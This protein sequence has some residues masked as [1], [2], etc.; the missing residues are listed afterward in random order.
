MCSSAEANVRSYDLTSDCT[1]P[2]DS[3]TLPS[4]SAS[5]ILCFA[6]PPAHPH[7]LFLSTRNGD[8]RYVDRRSSRIHSVA[9]GLLPASAA[10][11]VVTLLPSPSSPH[12]LYAVRAKAELELYDLRLTRPERRRGTQL[13]RGGGVKGRLAWAEMQQE[14]E[15]VMLLQGERGEVSAVDWLR[16]EGKEVQGRWGWEAD[17]A[18][19]LGRRKTAV[20]LRGQR[21]QR[22]AAIAAHATAGRQLKLSRVPLRVKAHVS[23][24]EEQEELELLADMTTAT[25]ASPQQP[26]Q[27]DADVIGS[28][29]EDEDAALR[30]RELQQS[31]IE[32]FFSVAIPTDVGGVE[33]AKQREATPMAKGRGRS[34][35]PCSC[36]CQCVGQ[37]EL[38]ASVSVLESHPTLSYV[39]C[40][41][42]NNS[43]CVVAADSLREEK[44]EDDGREEEAR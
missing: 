37:V 6:Q 35:L 13:W 7:L 10:N 25:C 34:S 26:M 44:E 12:L 15:G 40:G 1:Q 20:W 3:F 32:R 18:A 31:G 30:Q 24:D 2:V 16:G 22:G 5:P 27:L 23:S 17:T 4:A 39:V 41:L 29:S 28:D 11:A 42:T 21:P 36:C 19:A 14:A 38:K 43:L 9:S 33:E 8:F